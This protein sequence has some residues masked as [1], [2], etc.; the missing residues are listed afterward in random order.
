MKIYSN[1]PQDYTLED[2]YFDKF[3]DTSL[4]D[5]TT[6]M[7]FYFMNNKYALDSFR[8]WWIE[9]EIRNCDDDA[10]DYLN[11]QAWGDYNT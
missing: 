3:N 6:D 2:Y 1:D 9:R 5:M 7:I 4:S 10:D 11:D 8:E